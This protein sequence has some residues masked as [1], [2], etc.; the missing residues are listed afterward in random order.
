M[1][2]N[3]IFFPEPKLEASPEELGL[4]CE[5]LFFRAQDKPLLHGWLIPGKGNPASI[6]WFH[7]NAGNISHRLENILL[8][9]ERLPLNIFIFDY[10][11]YGR[12]EGRPTEE[13]TYLDG[14][15]ALKALKERKEVDPARILYFGR[16]LGSAVAVELALEEPPLGL[17]LE[18]PFTSMKELARRFL[19]FPPLASLVRTRY[20]TLSRIARLK[21]P[22]LIIHG[23][24]DEIV[25]FEQ[26]RR[27][28]EEAPAPKR[29]FP[30]PR[31]G[32]NDCYIVGGEP[33]FREIDKFVRRLEPRRQHNS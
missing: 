32:H 3:F 27:L 13:G 11:G 29:F 22:I 2:E 17:I 10:R 20:D 6:L 18:S 25:P 28:F 1:E 12:S 30:V 14:R 15:A 9:R 23:E 7:G 21:A 31:A 19:P 4:P 24:Q 26:G 8:L 5:E 16:S 33:Y